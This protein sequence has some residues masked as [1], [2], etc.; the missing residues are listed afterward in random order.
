MDLYRSGRCALHGGKST[1][2]K[3]AEGK[4]RSAANGK[5][6]PMRRNRILSCAALAAA[7]VREAEHATDSLRAR[8]EPALDPK[9]AKPD[10]ATNSA[11]AREARDDLP[12]PPIPASA[13]A[14]HATAWPC[15]GKPVDPGQAP[16]SL[17]GWAVMD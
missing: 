15:Y 7:E 14:T 9:V 2:P 16:R 17:P 10:H 11:Q 6:N 3:T 12:K 4:A 8:E 1:G 13:A 5:A